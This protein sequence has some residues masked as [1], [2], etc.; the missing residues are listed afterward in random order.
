MRWLLLK[1]LQILRRSPLL[2]ALLVLYPI[3]IAGLVGFA[4]TS[5]PGKPKV[6]FLNEVP[7]EA[8]VVDL[9]GERVDVSKE[10]LPLFDAIDPVRVRSREEALQ[11]VR[12]G[13]VLAALIVPQNLTQ[14]LQAAAGGTFEPATV[15]VYYN[16]EDPAKRSF[17]E[18]TIQAQVQK[19]NAAL[20]KRL[21]GVAVNYLGLITDG[22]TIDLF[23]R[24][25]NILGLNKSVAILTSIRDNVPA[26]DR[27]A[28][29][30]VINFARLASENLDLSDDIL[31][32]VGTPISVKTTVVK[33]GSE[34]LGAFAI[35]IAVAVTL[36][37]VT[38]LLA[39]GALALEREEN[40]FR[41][42]VRGLVS[43]TGLLA[44][45]VA[46]AAACS[47]I[48]GFLL[49]AGLSVV[50]VHL[51]WGRVPL[52]IVALVF[53][54]LAFGAMGVAIGVLTR[55]V[56]AASLLAFMASLPI[57]VLAL[58]PSGAVGT[59][60]YDVI[61]VISALFPFKPTLDALNAAVNSSG[62]LGGP[63]LHLT[64]LTVA[65]LGL[66]RLGLRRFA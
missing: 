62:G 27:P 38:L 11:K 47:T 48:V 22:G 26:R 44:E 4:V 42:L 54:A 65:F 52:W 57:A 29:D 50:G 7:R 17:V 25:L 24:T 36:M 1:D 30:Q 8:N 41:R 6:A 40:A 31:K 56:R 23:G 13:E 34:P 55:E 39:A 14:K 18:N 59:G 12:D 16:A 45:K 33:G 63:L 19:A 20:T 28:L 46:L 53:G 2:V 64:L 66:A 15:E 10:A 35:V 21:T 49:L 32:A 43:R 37:F 51:G 60:L 9:G 61:R 58:V 5:G 3:V